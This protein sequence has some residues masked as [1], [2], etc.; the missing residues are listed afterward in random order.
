MITKILTFNEFTNT[1]LYEA[2]ALRFNVFVIEQQC[3]YPEFDDVDSN[4]QHMLL[5]NDNQVIGYL[6]IYIDKDDYA[7][8][9]RIVTHEAHRGE[10][11]GR[12]II[13]EAINFISTSYTNK[14]IKINA[15]EHLKAFYESFGFY[16][17]ENSYLD[18]GIYHIDML[19]DLNT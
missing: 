19:L 18:Y 6:R 10:N 17:I 11:Y 2:L 12:H 8:I 15:Q 5:K 13:N 4:A 1:E 9:G 7:R 3:I 16:K 14:T